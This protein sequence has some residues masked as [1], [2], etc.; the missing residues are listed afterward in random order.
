MFIE[1]QRVSLLNFNNLDVPHAHPKAQALG[2]AWLG[3]YQSS[4]AK[5]YVFLF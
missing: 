1:V 3:M 5:I 2:G 4:A